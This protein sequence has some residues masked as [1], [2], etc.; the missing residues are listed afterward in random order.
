M[1]TVKLV[2]R[3]G[4][5]AVKS[6]DSYD[7]TPVNGDI[8]PTVILHRASNSDEIIQLERGDV[9]YAENGSGKTIDVIR[10]PK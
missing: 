6:C 9:V 4:R 5:T 8:M 10:T 2:R 7:K 3:N 1:F